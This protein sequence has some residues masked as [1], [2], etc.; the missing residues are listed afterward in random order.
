MGVTWRRS[1]DNIKNPL[2]E[3][4]CDRVNWIDLAGN[5]VQGKFLKNPSACSTDKQPWVGSGPRFGLTRRVYV[6]RKAE[7]RRFVVLEA[8]EPSHGG[9]GMVPET[10]E[11]HKSHRC[12]TAGG[13]PLTKLDSRN[14]VSWEW[15]MLPN[16]KS[17]H[18]QE[19][20]TRCEVTCQLGLPV[21]NHD[22]SCCDFLNRNVMYPVSITNRQE[23]LK[24][25]TVTD[26]SQKVRNTFHFDKSDSIRHPH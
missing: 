6:V 24:M 13:W 8:E 25:E 10:N 21:K 16:I 18:G 19:T 17:S 15:R 12:L 22:K 5:K 2:Q 20:L 4:G 14:K 7:R 9:S 26:K 11:H 3:I 23:S 1:E